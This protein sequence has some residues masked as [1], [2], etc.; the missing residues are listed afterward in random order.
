MPFHIT[1]AQGGFYQQ[2]SWSKLPHLTFIS[3]DLDIDI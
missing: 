2:F 3:A 1:N